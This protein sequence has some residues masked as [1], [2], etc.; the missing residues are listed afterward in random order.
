M[1]CPT[2][3]QPARLIVVRVCTNLFSLVFVLFL[4]GFPPTVKPQA[5]ASSRRQAE[6]EVVSI[7][8][9]ELAKPIAR[10][11]TGGEVHPYNLALKVDE[12]AHIDVDQRGIDLAV[13]TFDP[14][15]KKIS[16]VDAFR[17]GEKEAV[18][19]V[20]EVSGLYR[21]EV[22]TTF[23]KVPTGQYEINVPELRPATE[24]DKVSYRGG[25]LIAEA[26]E[27]ER[28]QNQEAWRKAVEKYE[29]ALPLWQ[30][31]KDIA[32]EANTLYLIAGVYITLAEK[33]KAL[34]FA[35]RAV[36]LAETAVRDSNE[37]N[38]TNAL[39]VQAW[40]LD[41]LGRAHNEFGDKKKAAELFN[42]ALSIRKQAN[43]RPGTIVTLNNLAIAYQSMGDPRKALEYLIEIRDLLKGMG[44]RAKEAS[45]LN[46][47]CVIHEDIAEYGK[48]LEYCNQALSIRRDLEDER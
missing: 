6:S 12:Y 28:K 22:H 39:T 46:N 8:S 1:S 26:F 38:R 18:G 15:G 3:S 35:N 30:S 41:T 25:M 40:A 11:I 10:Q 5:N 29:A 45:F 34:D 24:R 21:I 19:I 17:V 7:P 36:S 4:S 48:A 13:W 20:A 16:E 33:Q 2:I 23:P 47:I 31:I 32:W 14:T 27:L 37:K 44:D 42:Q 43:D 9:L